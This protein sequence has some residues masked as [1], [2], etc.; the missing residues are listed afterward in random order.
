MNGELDFEA[1]LRARVATLEG[2][3]DSVFATVGAQV[4]VTARRSRA[5]RRR[6]RAGGAPRSSP[7]GST[8]CSTRSPTR[9][10]LD[11]WRANRLEVRDGHLTGG[12][13]GP[14]VDAAAKAAHARRVGGG[15]GHP[16][17]TDCCGGRRRQRPADDGDHRALGRLRREGAGAGSRRRADRRA[18]SPRCCRSCS[19]CRE[20]VTHSQAAV[21]GDDGTGDVGGVVAGA[22]R[23]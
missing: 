3:P 20:L 18:T 11:L 1:S 22:A 17:V 12:L 16:A 13:T 21:D 9:V 4:T 8:R 2:L 23:R 6:P 5:D 14:I 15:C 7:A 10:G 19:D